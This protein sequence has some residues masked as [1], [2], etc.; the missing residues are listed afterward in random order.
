MDGVSGK[1]NLTVALPPTYAARLFEARD[2]GATDQQ[3][4]NIAAEAL[5]ETYFRDGGRR[6]GGLLVEF[7]DVEHIEFDL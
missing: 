2:Q 1:R 7:T 4:Q 3:L 5:Q 6:A